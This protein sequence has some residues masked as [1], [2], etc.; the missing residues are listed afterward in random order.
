MFTVWLSE[1]NHGYDAQRKKHANNDSRRHVGGLARDRQ[2]GA[3][4]N[5]ETPRPATPSGAQPLEPHGKPAQHRDGR[6][7]VKQEDKG[8]RK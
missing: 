1:G 4:R 6:R 7:A 2:A 8:A 5:G 3:V